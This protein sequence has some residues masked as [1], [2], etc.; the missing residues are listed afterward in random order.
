MPREEDIEKH[1]HQFKIKYASK[2]GRRRLNSRGGRQCS[3]TWC[4][5]ER[6]C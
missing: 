5:S 1:G 4:G 6:V 3:R 2:G